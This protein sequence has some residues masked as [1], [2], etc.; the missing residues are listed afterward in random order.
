[1]VSHW[2]SIAGKASGIHNWIGDYFRA[3]L[4]T[5]MLGAANLLQEL[6]RLRTVIGIA[7]GDSGNEE[8]NGN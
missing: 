8:G 7:I 1:M 2:C 5:K 4:S 3:L 6:H